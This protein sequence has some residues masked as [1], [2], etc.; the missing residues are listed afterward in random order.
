MWPLCT[1][2]SLLWL[3]LPLLIGLITGW[4]AWGHKGVR[5]AS[6]DDRHH[7]SGPDAWPRP[8]P[9]SPGE[10]RTEIKPTPPLKVAEGDSTP[11]IAPPPLAA[12]GIPAAVGNP[13]DLRQIKGIGPKLNDLL[14]SLG[15]RRFDQIAA[16]GRDEI[17]KVDS[18]LGAFSGRIERDNWVE[19]AKLLARGAVDEFNARFG[20]TGPTA[21]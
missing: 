11:P 19:Q 9:A 3:L 1:A 5:T 16:W 6:N 17:A 18:H 13:D 12:I 20:G 14:Q 15:V 21:A 7:G 8:V 4:W 2:N 10:V